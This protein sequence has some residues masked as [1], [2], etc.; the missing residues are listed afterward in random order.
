MAPRR[1]GGFALS[2]VLPLSLMGL[3]PEP[4]RAP[5]SARYAHWLARHRPRG[6]PGPLGG[7]KEG[8]RRTRGWIPAPVDLSHIRGP[9]L[10]RGEGAP[11][12][13][14]AFDLRTMGLLTPVKDQGPY[15]TCWTFACMGSL[16]GSLLRSGMGARDLSE[17]SLAYF[18]YRPFNASLM[19]AFTPGPATYGGDAIF[20]QGGS[21]WMSAAILGRGTGAVAGRDCPYPDGPYRAEPRPRG[22]LPNGREEVQVPLSQVL[23]LFNGEV[24]INAEDVKTALTQYGPVVIAVDWEDADF[25]ESW[26]AFR[27]TSAQAGDLNHE[28]CIV[29]WDDAYPA[30][31][32]PKGNRPAADGAWIVRNS[33]SSAWG[34]GGYFHISYDSRV[35][36]GT[37][38][39]GEPKATR[40]LYQYDPLGWCANLG[41]GGPD[42]VCANVFR[43][44]QPETATAVAFYTPAVRTSFEVTLLGGV[45]GDPGTGTPLGP[46]L[47][48]TLQAPGFHLVHFPGPVPVPRG[49]F[50]AVLKLHTP[51]YAYPVSVQEPVEGYSDDSRSHRGRS[52]MSRDG[53]AWRD[54]APTCDGAAVC[55]KVVV[56]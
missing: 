24:P 51:G 45:T 50:A 10:T 32:F 42:A 46:P 12:F 39:V 22:D 1:M 35:F 27:N 9:V 4:S 54:L 47:T 14:P 56:E 16:E 48:G 25:D 44:G 21:D 55:L 41:Y 19:A 26:S 43:A 28:V 31:R 7:H 6:A 37:A 18:A 23:Y 20:D 34:E 30:A 40:R 53:K 8:G 29:G 5:L 15:G 38:F 33:W 2:L 49:G 52:F 11:P 13:P 36:D 17:W 3:E